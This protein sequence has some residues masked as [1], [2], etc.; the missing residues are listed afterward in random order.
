MSLKIRTEAH[1]RKMKVISSGTTF[2]GNCAVI[3]LTLRKDCFRYRLCILI[4]FGFSLNVET[5]MYNP[6]RTWR[7]QS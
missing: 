5:K 4:V 7:H 2:M 1:A 3:S 6:I